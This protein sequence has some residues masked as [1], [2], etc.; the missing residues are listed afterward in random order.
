MTAPAHQA[1]PDALG[2]VTPARVMKIALPIV[3][4][5]ATVPLLGIVDTAVVGQLGAAAPLG[6]VAV[7]AIILSSLYWVFG[8]LRMGTVGL[9]S[10]ARGQGD[11]G[12]VAAL[13]T[14]VV[15]IGAGAGLAMVVLQVPLIA[16]A[17]WLASPS[18]EVTA[19]AQDYLVV[20]IWSAPAM[21]AIY[22][23]SGWLIAQERSQ[24]FMAVQIWM[25]GLNIVLDVWFVLGLGWGVSGVAFATFL[26]EWSGLA[27]GLWFCRTGFQGSAW[28]N[29]AQVLKAE[30]LW[31][32]ASVNGDI[33]IRSLLLQA[34]FTSF[35]FIAARQGDLA[36]A[37]NQVLMQMMLLTAYGMDGFAFAA[38]TLVG[39]AFGAKKRAALRRSAIVT[40]IGGAAVAVVM[41]LAFWLLGGVMIDMMSTAP[42]VRE[43][44]RM[45]LPYVVAAPLLG[46]AAWM[47]DGIFIGATATRDMR[48]MMVVSAVIYGV[49]LLLLLP[50]LGNHGLWLAL[51]I[52]FV[53][54]GVTLALRYPALEARAS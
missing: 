13:L 50:L 8:F 37:A 38:E 21:I 51:L 7:G 35:T 46:C 16:G 4:S 41:A 33:L 3:M 49:S 31:H 28:R 15:L 52:S 54:R 48:N 9:A 22:G 19:L 47:L 44:A 20:R 29:W 18:A 34:M 23:L 43:T 27:L 40:S 14:R 39:Q 17:L 32:M 10:Q 12:E 36:L 6:A 45:F 25:N 53:A 1:S 42:D 24:A 26:A 11:T 5:N 30:R 2:S